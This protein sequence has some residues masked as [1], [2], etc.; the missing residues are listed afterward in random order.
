MDGIRLGAGPMGRRERPAS[1]SGGR[2]G[3]PAPVAWL[4]VGGRRGLRGPAEH[5]RSRRAGRAGPARRPADP[6]GR[7]AGRIGR[8]AAPEPAP[9]AVP[10][11]EPTMPM[12]HSDLR[13]LI[14][15]GV[16]PGTWAELGSGAGAFTLALADL[17]GTGAAIVSVDR[18][19]AALDRQ[20][21]A[22][23]ARFPEAAVDY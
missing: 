9:G 8:G 23:A 21:L 18:D 20:R 13:R 19:A 14:E 12:D 1:R 11:S 4:P 10:W 5:G 22:M 2:A 7:R 3:P 15:D 6:A 16:A 17:L